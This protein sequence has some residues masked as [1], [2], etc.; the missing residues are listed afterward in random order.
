MNA[1]WTKLSLY[2]CSEYNH[3][4]YI[5]KIDLVGS[6][7]NS[8]PCLN[9]SEYK[10]REPEEEEAGCAMLA[11]EHGMAIAHIDS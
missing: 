6:Y 2:L 8:C 4:G 1:Q 9:P 3:L 7:N 11:Y 5:S 10:E